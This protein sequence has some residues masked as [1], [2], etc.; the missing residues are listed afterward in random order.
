LVYPNPTSN[1]A[2]LEFTTAS[3]VKDAKVKIYNIS[4]K[5]MKTIRKG[6]LPGGKHSLRLDL[7][8]LPVGNYIMSLEA[9]ASSGVSKFVIMR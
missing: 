8:E 6:N 3:D 5:L 4:G 2:T 9:G 7:S 1:N